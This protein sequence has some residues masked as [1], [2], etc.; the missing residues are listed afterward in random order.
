MSTV[1]MAPGQDPGDEPEDRDD[2]ELLEGQPLERCDDLLVVDEPRHDDAEDD[3]QDADDDPD[4]DERIAPARRLG[5]GHRRTRGGRIDLE[6]GA[7]DGAS[8]TSPRSSLTLSSPLPSRAPTSSRLDR[9]DGTRL[10]ARAR[11][12][13]P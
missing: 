8:P 13:A 6:R 2:Q 4:P 11:M 12:P 10:M 7:V 9:L 3:D 5:L 1:K